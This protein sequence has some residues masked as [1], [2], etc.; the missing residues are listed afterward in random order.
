MQTPARP[1]RPR[2]AL[3]LL[4]AAGPAGLTTP[5]IR[6][7]AG[8]DGPGST[9]WYSVV[10]KTLE[11]R[12]HITKL[13]RDERA[14]W[15]AG[16][17]NRWAITD[18]GLARLAE[19]DKPKEAK[20][21]PQSARD[22]AREARKPSLQMAV[23]LLPTLHRPEEKYALAHGLREVGCTLDEIAGVFGTSREWIR[24]VLAQQTW[25]ARSEHKEAV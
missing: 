13:G 1:D 23:T 8:E 16:R 17:P 21:R 9:S 14:G 2:T 24:K 15:Q 3:R 6:T 5:D 18:A 10:L 7:Q 4:A 22:T 11:D 20:T 12:G 19:Y 25:R